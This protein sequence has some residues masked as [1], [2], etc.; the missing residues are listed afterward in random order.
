MSQ[1]LALELLFIGLLGLAS[2]AIAWISGVVV[3]KL[4]KGSAD[5]M[6]ELP[7]DLPAEL[8]PLSWLIG[9]WEGSGVIDYKV[10]DESVTHEFGQR[11]SFS[12]DGMPHLNYTSYTWLFPEEPGGDPSP[13]ATETGYWRIERALGEGDPGPALLPAVGE[14]R[15]P[16]AESVETLRNAAGG[17]DLEVSLVHPGGVAE[18]YLG[19]VKG[20]ASTSPPTPSCAPPARRTTRRP[21][22]S[23]ASS[24]ATCSGR[25]TSPRSART[26]ART[27]RRAWRR[28][29][30]DRLALPL[31]PRG[32]ARRG[33]RRRV[34]GHYGNP[35][36]EQRRL[37]RGE[38]IVDLSDRGVL[39]V[40]GPDRLSWLHSMAS[41]ALD[42]L[43][44][45][46]AAEALF[47]DAS[48]RIE[49]VVHVVDDGESTLARRRGVGCRAAGRLPRPHAVHAPRRGRRPH[50]R[51]R[52]ARRD[53]HVRARR[54][55]ARVAPNGVAL[56]WADPWAAPAPG[57]HRYA[58]DAGHPAS[59][60]HWIER[61]VP[62]TAL[63]DAAE[64][65][66]AGRVAVAGSLAAE[67]L[68]IA[69]WRPR[70][71]TEVDEK[72]IPHE[73]DWLRSAV[74]LG[75][76]CYKGQ[77]TVAKVLNLGRPPRRLVLL[78]LDGSDTVLPR[79]G[80]RG[81]GREGPARARRG[82]G[83]RATRG[84]PHHVER[85]APRARPGRARGREARRARRPPAHRREP[86]HRRRRRTG[87]DRP[88]RRRRGGRRATT[89]EARRP[90]VSAAG[91][92]AARLAAGSIRLRD[93][94]PAIL[95]ITVTAVAAYAFAFFVLGHGQPLIAAIVAITALGFVRDARPVR[96]LETVV[97]MTL[98]IV[99]AEVLLLAFGAGVWQYAL[100]LALTLALARLVSANAAFA[101]AAA[102]QCTLVML[103]P[104]PEGG[105]F[106]RT[107]DAVVGGAF[108]LAATAIIPRD[109]HRA[110]TRE[111]RRLID[112]HV[113][114]LGEL[115][116]ALRSGRTDAAGRALSRAR[117][118]QPLVEA[119][120]AS[121]DSGSRSRASRRSCTAR[122]ST[123]NA[124]G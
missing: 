50:G 20:R 110:A 17:F 120:M 15:Y 71:A 32:R 105:P 106:V 70:L 124:S 51:V 31:A 49:H 102:V 47:L 2:L 42:R 56:D 96:V 92:V 57:A 115:A 3:Y 33:R 95:Q 14:T 59:A 65:V 40:T 91:R 113:A 6:I 87:R 58:P 103:V 61:I 98:G 29:T 82:R 34:P 80:R 13:L 26:C 37:E 62:R 44:P 63:A 7:V 117:A 101:I 66:R 60:W 81:R 97:A 86:R 109:P 90:Q 99:L 77:E 19:Q 73:L 100:A 104:A 64:A 4:F 10:G 123:S 23:T 1:L 54:R 27:P 36:V 12:H 53:V 45:G 121:V 85:D 46:V 9:V 69:A 107:L 83:A 116:E 55:G 88:G 94:V 108:A 8:V 35:I 68:R 28:W 43:A 25:G 30:D 5:P 78:H 74:D 84:R 111:G 38:A 18:L 48:G 72:T 52:R 118:T 39:T 119:W 22:G 114:V 11:V 21:P 76:G 93:S 122:S 112:E 75:K 89:A 67:A 79:A 24:R 41:Q 16:D